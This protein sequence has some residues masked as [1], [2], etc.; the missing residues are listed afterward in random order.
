M[1][2]EWLLAALRIVARREFRGAPPSPAWPS[3]DESPSR[4]M[5]CLSDEHGDLGELALRE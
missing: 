2:F 4:D 1:K 3:C 5:T